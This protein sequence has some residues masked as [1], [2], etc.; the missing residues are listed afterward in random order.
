VVASISLLEP[1]VE[2]QLEVQRVREVPVGLEV[3]LHIPLQTLDR[4]LRL[5]VSRRTEVPVEAQL[6]AEPSMGV[7]RASAAGMQAPPAARHHQPWQP[8]DLPQA[9][10]HAP[11]HVRCFLRKD[12]RAGASP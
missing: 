10:A 5:R 8:A 6:P 4:A 11:Q 9:A 3:A 7:G 1:R 12:Q 2:L